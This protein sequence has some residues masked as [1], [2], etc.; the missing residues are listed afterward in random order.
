MTDLGRI[1]GPVVIP[2]C[3]MVRLEWLTPSSRLI[4]NILHTIVAPGFVANVAVANALQT[5]IGGHLVTSGLA[6]FMPAATSF[7]NVGLRDLRAANLPLVEGTGAGTAGTSASGAFPA[8]VALVCTLRTAQA[9]RAFR[10]RVY[11]PN[12]ATNAAVA[13]GTASAAAQTAVETFMANVIAD[14]A[15]SAMT[16]CIAQPARAQYTTA[17]G[18]VIPA[19]AA[20]TVPVAAALVRNGLFDSQRRRNEPS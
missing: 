2:N 12:W 13:A 20:N 1:P 18:R 15:A 17:K 19:R 11:I 3:V 4:F 8:N 14:L 6:A 7:A 10:G 9:G 5:A 16:L